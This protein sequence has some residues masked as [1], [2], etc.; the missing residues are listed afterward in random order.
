MS[1]N[2]RGIREIAYF[3]CVGGGQVTVQGN[4]AYIGH[5]G[6]TVGT[7]IV[8]VKDP[9]N[10]KRLAEIQVPEG[11]QSHKVRVSGDIMI[12]NRE[13]PPPFNTKAGFQGG[14]GIFDVSNPAN[15]REIAFWKCAP[16]GIPTVSI[17]MV[18]TLISRLTLRAIT[19]TS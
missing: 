9:A 13:A 8:D 19:V 12:V 7:T 6:G 11:I 5:I 2:S 15:P 10:P 4:H 16:P 14:L 3:D 18:T 17:S 1:S